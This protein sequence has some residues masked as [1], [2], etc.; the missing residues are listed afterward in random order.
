MPELTITSPY[1]LLSR[2][3]SNTF[4]MGI[5]QPYARVDFI[6]QL[7]T[8]DLASVHVVLCR[9]SGIKKYMQFLVLYYLFSVI[10]HNFIGCTCFKKGVDY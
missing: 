5:G 2:V 7:G 1:V 9:N 6:P 3:D 4:I 10:Y 8:L